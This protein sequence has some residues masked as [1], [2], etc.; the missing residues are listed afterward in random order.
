VSTVRQLENV[1]TIGRVVFASGQTDRQTFALIAIL[2]Q[3]GP[4][5]GTIVV[6]LNFTKY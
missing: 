2:L 4:K 6:R 5:I 1:V 3:C